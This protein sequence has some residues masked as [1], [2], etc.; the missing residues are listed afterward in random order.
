M[1][2]SL[3]HFGA[4]VT[5]LLSLFVLMPPSFAQTLTGDGL[6]HGQWFKAVSTDRALYNPSSTVRFDA[7]FRQQVSGKE[8]IVVYEHLDSVLASDTLQVQ[9]ADNVI[10][11][12]QVPG[13]D[14]YGMMANMYLVS[15]DTVLDHTSIGV[16]ISSNWSKF[17]RYGFLSSYPYMTQHSMDSIITV[18]NRYH[19]NGLQFYD[20]QYKH[21]EPLA[22]TVQNPD[23]TW[24]DIGN[25]TTYLSTVEGYIKYAHERGMKAMN[26]NLLY[27]AYADAFQDGVDLTW[28]LFSDPDH[29]SRSYFPLPPPTWASNLYLMDPGNTGWKDYI[30]AQERRAFLAIPFDG[31]HVDQLGDLGAEYDYDGQPVNLPGTFTSFLSGA[32]SQL[33]VDLVMNAVGQYGQQE[34]AQAPVDFLYTEVWPPDTTYADLVKIIGQNTTYSN[35]RLA[36]V[37][38]AYMDDISNGS[39]YFNTPG[40]L[41]TDATIFADGGDHLELGE[42]MLNGAYFP[43]NDLQMSDL[44][45]RELTHYY[46]F[47]VAYENLLRDG[48]SPASLPLTASIGQTSVSVS[49]QMQRGSIWSFVSAK[50]HSVILSLINLRTAVSLNWRDTGG[51]QSTP[52]TVKSLN[53]SFSSASKIV[54]IWCASPDFHDGSPVNLPFSQT[55]TNVSVTVPDLL[56]WDMMVVQFDSTF[57]GIKTSGNGLPRSFVLSQNY[58]NPFNPQTTISYDVPFATNVSIIVYN[59]L[60]QKVADLVNGYTPA[61][62]H[63]VAFNA[64]GMS[65]GVYFCVMKADGKLFTTKMVLVK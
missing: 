65:S 21:N 43:A 52:D 2:L 61:G 59:V 4:S 62:I 11:P 46:D 32:K 42:H 6:Q 51:K 55:G 28:S 38:A 57:T 23:S 63:Q 14:Y 17:P 18:L 27:G 60:G 31:W 41:F 25:R 39:G 35:G 40:V 34:I 3:S 47:M 49:P 16:D 36:T 9:N 8:L 29:Q 5:V 50:K 58:P 48:E 7:T 20:W 24:K 19:I 1:K 53:L 44:L 56:Y 37:L 45:K 22:G 54:K 64:S 15:Q 30:Y 10:W 26:Y 12:W 13:V 33:N